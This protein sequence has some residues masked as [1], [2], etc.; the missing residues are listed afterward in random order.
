MNTEEVYKI[1]KQIHKLVKE[2]GI[3]QLENLGR[4]DLKV[5]SKSSEVDLVTEVDKESEKKI[6]AF[7]KKN[8]PEHG[9]LGEESGRSI[10]NQ[11]SDYLWIID[12]VDGTTNYAHGYPLFSIAIALQY[13]QETL[14]GSIY[15][16]YIDEF[17]WAIKGEG[18]YLN[19]QP[20]H[21]SSHKKLETAL[22]ATGFPY[23][24]KTT[25]NN[26]LDYFSKIMPNVGGVR[27]SGS[28][29]VD[30]AFV[31]SGR[32]EGYFEMY[33][34]QWDFIAGQLMV[35]EAGGICNSKPLG[36]KYAVVATNSYIME[37]L[38]EQLYSVSDRD[39]PAYKKEHL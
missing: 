10:A 37:E 7:I 3:Y 20:I 35:R 33:I 17:Y 24:K 6:I 11:N 19:E 5:D 12:P 8:F 39:Y 30:L 32:T 18:A 16:P 38:V 13:K 34:N 28:A 26:N 27:R 2:L 22:L 14:L 21:V 25:K 9:I 23:N 36:E 29:C 31:A 15:I 4:H 1:K